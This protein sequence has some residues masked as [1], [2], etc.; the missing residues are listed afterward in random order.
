MQ[1][2]QAVTRPQK[3][4]FK[5]VF[6]Y[7][8][9]ITWIKESKMCVIF[10][11]VSRVTACGVAICVQV[12]RESDPSGT[13]GE[14]KRGVVHLWR[15]KRQPGWT[16]PQQHYFSE[17]LTMESQTCVQNIV[18]ENLDWWWTGY[19]SWRHRPTF[20]KLWILTHVII[21]AEML[22]VTQHRELTRLQFN[23]R[24]AVRSP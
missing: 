24:W 14:G 10:S 17:V 1:G 22:T 21:F 7:C 2:P 23:C 18:F 13:D 8:S 6:H 11:W 19:R 15:P 4:F 9:C 20:L 16:C 3:R 5:I 12:S